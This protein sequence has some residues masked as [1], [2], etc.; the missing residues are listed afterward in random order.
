MALL[1]TLGAAIVKEV[2]AIANIKTTIK[3]ILW[4]LKYLTNLLKVP[5]KSFGFSTGLPIGP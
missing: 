1:V 2:L 3:F 4:G 5:L